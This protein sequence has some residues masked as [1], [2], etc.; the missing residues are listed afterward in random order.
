MKDKPLVSIVTPSYNQGRFIEDTILSVKNQDYP[1]IEHI[2]VDGGSTDNT[3]DILKKYEG[4]YNMRWISRSDRGQADAVNRGFKMARGKIIGWLNS[5][6]VFF[7]KDV[8]SFIV[9][10]FEEFGDSADVIYGNSVVIDENKRI[11]KFVQTVPWHSFSRLLRANYIEQPSVFL[12]KKVVQ[13]FKLD[14]NIDLPMDYE[15]WLRLSKNGV[16]FKYVNKILSAERWHSAA[17][18]IKRKEEMRKEVRKLRERY[19]QKFDFKYFL[20]KRLDNVLYTPLLIK[21][22][23]IN[24]FI[25]GRFLRFP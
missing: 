6:D 16:K 4:T 17:K 1:N 23:A 9:K 18:S 5:D 2:I 20:L 15:Y 19:G 7:T 25:S 12:R 22:I 3:L 13:K 11:L 14:V 10:R 24:L 21:W 8:V